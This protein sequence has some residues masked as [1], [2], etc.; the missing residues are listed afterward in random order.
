[1][2]KLF[3]QNEQDIKCSNDSFVGIIR[4]IN[5]GR[6]SFTCYKKLDMHDS[7]EVMFRPSRTNFRYQYRALQLLPDNMPFL[8]K[9]LFPA[10]IIPMDLPTSR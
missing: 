5:T 3:M 10:K 9:F 7:Y 6:I 4:A 2:K 8:K 1:M